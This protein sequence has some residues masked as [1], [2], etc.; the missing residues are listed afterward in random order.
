MRTDADN[1]IREVKLQCDNT[2]NQ[3]RQ[4][5]ARTHREYR[6]ERDMLRRKWLGIEEPVH[7]SEPDQS[8]E[9][10]SH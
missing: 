10:D 9:T 4:H 7:S 3:L 2:L 6:R 5:I 1:E 8:E